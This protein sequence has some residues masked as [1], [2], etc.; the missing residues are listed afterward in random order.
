MTPTPDFSQMPITFPVQSSEIAAYFNQVARPQD[1]A[2]FP[3]AHM[4]LLPEITAG[5]KRVGFASWAE[6]ESQ[7]PQLVGKIDIVAYNAEHWQ[8]TPREEQQN[9]PETVKRAAEVTHQ[10]GFQFMFSPD[11]RFAQDYLG[12]VAP[13]VD[14]IG[15]QGQRLQ[16]D[17]EA[18]AAWVQKMI[19][20]ARA[21]NPNVEIYV[22][23]GAT[24]GPATQ[25]LAAI[26]T[27]A[28]DID[29]ISVWSTLKTFDT[30]QE[31]VTLLRQSSAAAQELTTA[32]PTPT[33][34]E[35]I[36]RETSTLIPTPTLTPLPTS[37]ESVLALT[38]TLTPTPLPSSTPTLTSTP[39]TEGATIEE[40]ATSQKVVELPN[41]SPT[42]PASQ[43][44]AAQAADESIRSATWLRQM[45]LIGAGLGVGL[46]AG[47]AISRRRRSRDE[48]TQKLDNLPK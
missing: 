28:D 35:I 7:L 47:L 2:A 12:E 6:A 5:R 29:G 34:T 14:I 21:S 30:L 37:D 27:V 38:S 44:E 18:F 46:L 26:Q 11:R 19:D 10:L 33:P 20:T 24:R 40:T 8:Q 9:L 13:Y 31:F 23:V 22:Q 4:H 48:A 43:P 25:M 1:I 39:D 15:L 45:A 17:P 16:E 3:E 36:A 41:P 32:L 42:M